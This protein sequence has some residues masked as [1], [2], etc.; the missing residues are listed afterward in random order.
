MI[1]RALQSLRPN[2]QWDLVGDKITW[3]LN[4]I[5]STEM[6]TIS[7]ELKGLDKNELGDLEVYVSDINP[8]HVIGAEPLPGDWDLDEKG[9][10]SLFAF[11]EDEYDDE[12]EEDDNGNGMDYDEETEVISDEE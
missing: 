3:K 4:A 5:P 9:Q 1:I 12:P 2:A 7:F 10:H 11:E 8:T 6:F